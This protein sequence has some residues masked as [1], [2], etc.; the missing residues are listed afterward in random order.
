MV[1]WQAVVGLGSECWAGGQARRAG[2]VGGQAR[3]GP[4]HKPPEQPPPHQHSTTRAGHQHHT[5]THPPAAAACVPRGC[6]APTCVVVVHLEKGIGQ[7]DDALADRLVQLE[8][9]LDH[10][11]QREL[12]P[13][14][15]VWRL[16]W[17]GGLEAGAGGAGSGARHRWRAD[18]RAWHSPACSLRPHPQPA[19]ALT[20]TTGSLAAAPRGTQS[21]RRRCRRCSSGSWNSRSRGGSERRRDAAPGPSCSTYQ[22]SWEYTDSCVRGRGGGTSGGGGG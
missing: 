7:V 15:V 9:L 10:Q 6:G 5:T 14:G 20:S 22:R 17:G 21:S 1:G 11:A 18:H 19:L 13:G 3:R 4:P 2:T 12:G 8:A 16:G